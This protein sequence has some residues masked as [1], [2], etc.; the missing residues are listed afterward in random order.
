MRYRDVLPLEMANISLR[1]DG[2]VIDLTKPISSIPT[3]EARSYDYNYWWD[4][5]SPEMREKQLDV[6]DV[7]LSD[8]GLQITLSNMKLS[9]GRCV[10]MQLSGIGLLHDEFAYTINQLP[11]GE[12]CSERV[13]KTV[14]P[15]DARTVAEEGDGWLTTTWGDPF[16]NWVADLIYAVFNVDPG[17]IFTGSVGALIIAYVVRFFAIGV[18]GSEAGLASISTNI[19]LAAQSLGSSPTVLFFRIY[20]PLMRG[21]LASALVLV[22]VD[23]LKEL[24]ATLLLRPFNFDTLSTHIY[25]Q[26]SLE[27]FNAAAPAALVVVTLSLGAIILLA[28]AHR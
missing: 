21:A 10:R 3:I 28:K 11:E 7:A 4:Y 13:A 14:A 1:Q 12:L 26:A 25:S 15:P 9:A 2:F 22:F 17:L 6:G 16:D 5:G 24:P 23:T 18:G 19:P 27:N 8:D 20:Q